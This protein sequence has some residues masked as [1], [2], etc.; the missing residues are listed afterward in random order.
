MSGYL[1]FSQIICFKLFLDTKTSRKTGLHYC[2]SRV[3]FRVLLGIEVHAFPTAPL[4]F[5]NFS[6]L[7]KVGFGQEK[8]FAYISV[9]NVALGATD[10]AR[11]FLFLFSFSSFKNL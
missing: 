5:L 3:V 7:K 6:S 9:R 2:R 11:R 1:L 10:C 8:D 4:S